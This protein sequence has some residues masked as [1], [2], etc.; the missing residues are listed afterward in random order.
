MQDNAMI[1]KAI[2]ARWKCSVDEILSTVSYLR[3]LL[4]PDL[5]L[6]IENPD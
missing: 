6:R 4:W 1:A 3:L 2:I 5:Q